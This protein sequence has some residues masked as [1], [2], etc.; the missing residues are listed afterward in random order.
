M[1]QLF[2]NLLIN[3]LKFH[4]HSEKPV[5]EIS[6]KMLSADEINSFEILTEGINYIKI[7]FADNGIGFEQQFADQ[8]FQLF[9]RLHSAEDYEGTGDGLALCKKIVEIHHGH[10]FAL[11]EEN[12]GASF[13]VILPVKQ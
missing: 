9:E 7:K 5:I 12:K 8:I 10:I 1:N 13:Q 2:Y 11:A 3:A 4:N 6:Y